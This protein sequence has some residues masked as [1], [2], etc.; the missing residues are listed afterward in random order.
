[1]S[2]ATKLII[3]GVVVVGVWWYVAQKSTFVASVTYTCAEG[4]SIKASFYEGGP[5][6]PP[7]PGNP[8]TP[9]GSVRLVLSDGRTLTLKQTLSASG[10]R[11]S[12]GNP[13]IAGNESFVFWSKGNTALVIE[14]N[15]DKT[16]V[17]CVDAAQ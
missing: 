17:D 14:H 11:Y 5:A 2:L 12:D 13:S 10:I 6:S 3:A 8:P 4:K 16:Y 7:A 15:Q 1:M 9:T